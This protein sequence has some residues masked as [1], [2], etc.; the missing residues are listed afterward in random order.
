MGRYAPP[1]IEN[2]NILS[3]LF[4]LVNIQLLRLF[5]KYQA[6]MCARHEQLPLLT[7]EV[8]VSSPSCCSYRTQ[9]STPSLRSA[10][11]TLLVL[12]SQ[13]FSLHAIS[14]LPY[15]H[16]MER[17]ERYY[18]WHPLEAN[19]HKMPLKFNAAIENWIPQRSVALHAV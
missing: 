15:S 17:P 14:D 10:Q 11:G 6:C 9:T 19:T 1:A 18:S 12:W 7:R 13:F 4:C 8:H 2:S 16:Q 3:F 5:K